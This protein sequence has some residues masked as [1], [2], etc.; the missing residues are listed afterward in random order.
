MQANRCTRHTKALVI[1]GGIVQDVSAFA[2]H[3]FFRGIEWELFPTTVLSMADS[4]IG[5][6][7]G[8]NFE[9]N[10]NLIGAFEYPSRVT[11]DTQFASTLSNKDLFSGLAETLKSA[12]ISGEQALNEFCNCW[13]GPPQRAKLEPLIRQSLAIKKNFVEED[14]SDYGN[15]RMLNYGH[16]FGHAIESVTNYTVPHGIAVAVGID[17]INF[18]AQRFGLMQNNT[19]VRLH[20]IIKERFGSQIS[21]STNQCERLIE[22]ISEDKKRAESGINLAIVRS[23]GNWTIQLTQ[24]DADLIAAVETYCTWDDALITRYK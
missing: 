15:R 16:T 22:K 19:F 7:C 12:I 18:V 14:P 6:K 3:T 23:P 8:I 20:T 13:N 24:V 10:K 17:M 4:C 9:S 1:G 11:I 2:C 5:G 21:L